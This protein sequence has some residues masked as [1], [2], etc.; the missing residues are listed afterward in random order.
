MRSFI[1]PSS[2]N[3]PFQHKGTSECRH[4]ASVRALVVNCAVPDLHQTVRSCI[5]WMRLWRKRWLSA[6]TCVS[7]Q[8]L[9]ASQW[10]VTETQNSPM[11]GGACTFRRSKPLGMLKGL[12]EI[13]WQTL[14]AGG[15][16]QPPL[17]SI[18]SATQALTTPGYASSTFITARFGMRTSLSSFDL[19]AQVLLSPT[20]VPSVI[21]DQQRRFTC[22]LLRQKRDHSSAPCCSKPRA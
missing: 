12:R 1:V 11:L 16:C 18:S 6:A 4:N 20:C 19:V 14:E 2:S 13:L 3:D 22:S 17:A 15:T 5:T 8:R 7:H 21:Q 9:L 10:I